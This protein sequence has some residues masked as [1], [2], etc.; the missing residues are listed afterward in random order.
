MISPLLKLS[1]SNH[2]VRNRGM[3]ISLA[4][5]DAFVFVR[6]VMKGP[7]DLW[8]RGGSRESDTTDAERV[9]IRDANMAAEQRAEPDQGSGKVGLKRPAESLR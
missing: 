5:S 7:I 2:V 8:Q 6:R 1:V 9:G 3:L 4:S